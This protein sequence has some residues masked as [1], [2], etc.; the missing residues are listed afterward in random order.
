MYILFFKIN[1]K[2]VSENVDPQVYIKKNPSH[3][4]DFLYKYVR[5]NKNNRMSPDKSN[6]VY[7]GGLYIVWKT[8]TR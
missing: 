2:L 7:H 4:I 1:Y 6:S 3:S 5:L 8:C